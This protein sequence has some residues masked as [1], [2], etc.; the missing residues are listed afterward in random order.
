MQSGKTVCLCL[1]FIFLMGFVSS[2]GVAHGISEGI[3]EVT[4]ENVLEYAGKYLESDPV[5]ARKI[6]FSVFSE[7]IKEKDWETWF[8]MLNFAGISHMIQSGY[9]SAFFYYY[10]AM[11]VAL[12]KEDYVRVGNSLNNIAIAHG[13]M[14]N[15]IA[16]MENLLR[17]ADNYDLAGFPDQKGRI[18]YNIGVIYYE[19]EN[20]E[21]SLHNL[22]IS[23][24]TFRE[25]GDT[26][27][28]GKLFINYANLAHRMG[29]W[30]SALHY[31]DSAET[32]AMAGNDKFA[33]VVALEARAKIYMDL[34]R[35]DDASRIFDTAIELAAELG[36]DSGEIQL[37]L[38]YASLLLSNGD[39]F[40]SLLHASKARESAQQIGNNK[41]LYQAYGLLSRIY[42]ESGEYKD[43]LDYLSKYNALK[44][45][46]VNQ[47]MLHQV[48]NLELQR[49]EEKKQME[50]QAREELLNR[51]NTVIF[52]MAFAF[53]ASAIIV[54]LLSRIYAARQRQKE[55]QMREEAG[56][57]LAG[58]R[59][60]AALEAE[61]LERKRLGTELHDGVGP[62][63]SLAKLNITALIEKEQMKPEKKERILRSTDV[64]IDE[65][66]KEMRSISHNMAP[67]VLIEKGL[68]EA[69]KEMVR[70]L[71]DT[72]HCRLF[73]EL[74]GLDGRL[75]SYAEHAIYRTAQEIVNNSI[76]HSGANDIYIQ[77]TLSD[78]ELILMIEDD[79]KGFQAE[80]LTGNKGIGL[81]S[82]ASR[83]EGLHGRFLIDSAP[84]RGTIITAIVPVSLKV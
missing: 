40:R 74:P 51:K 20:Y 28:L 64:T 83:I 26:S 84:G 54:F 13:D 41:L 62:L 44:D 2:A 33:Y 75:Q 36:F 32:Y 50:L 24:Q 10:Q 39:T 53:V 76:V 25:A 30:E 27:S 61:V 68:E 15:Y 55:L 67:M 12:E 60:R 48:Y 38:G 35:W 69:L 77:F 9:D 21:Q 70:K 46:L 52:L 57:K 7:E 19:I 29:D 14:G 71:N 8:Q 58:E 80:L 47:N 5:K 79:G 73:L 23:Q 72:S 34:F 42:R 63:L 59:S 49:A 31:M 6:L 3:E 17:A 45:S 82:A 37:Q 11:E 1:L 78:D 22:K 18:H 4:A 16:S 56:M 43:A 65:I 66:L 81:K